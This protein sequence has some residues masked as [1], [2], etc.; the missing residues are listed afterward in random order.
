MTRAFVGVTPM[1]RYRLASLLPLSF[2]RLETRLTQLCT[3]RI[4]SCIIFPA[5]VGTMPALDRSKNVT[6]NSASNSWMERETTERETNSA[7]AARAM[8]RIS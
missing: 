5:S 2:S 7:L 4:M 8:L 6:P 3:W 1:R